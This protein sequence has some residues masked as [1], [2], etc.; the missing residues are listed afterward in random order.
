MHTWIY[1]Q[2][3]KLEY[4]LKYGLHAPVLWPSGSIQAHTHDM[5]SLLE[6]LQHCCSSCWW[7]DSQALA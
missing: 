5:Q 7:L 3:R 2:E 1:K 6:Q 4:T